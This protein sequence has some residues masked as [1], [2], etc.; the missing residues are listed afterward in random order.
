MRETSSGNSGDDA[1]ND[2][3]FRGNPRRRYRGGDSG[4]DDRSSGDRGFPRAFSRRPGGGARVHRLVPPA[5]ERLD[6]YR[7]YGAR[8]T[9]GAG[10][11]RSFF[12][13]SPS[14][15]AARFNYVAARI[16]FVGPV[17]L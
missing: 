3:D 1:R 10:V 5:P 8:A 9:S 6:T 11:T 16:K 17:I 14:L 15:A 4:G 2:S 13:Y 12:F 7:Y